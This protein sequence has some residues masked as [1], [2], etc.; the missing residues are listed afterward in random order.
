MTP[1]QRAKKK[2]RSTSK[3]RATQARYNQTRYW[4]DIKLLYGLTKEKYE[5]IL[6]KQGGHC[7][8][9]LRT[10]QLVVDHDHVT[11]QVRGILCLPHNSGLGMIGDDEESVRRVLAYIQNARS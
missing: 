7:A 5:N 11:G 10:N 9:C 4:A 2:Y 3:Y 6:Q 8:L 1:A